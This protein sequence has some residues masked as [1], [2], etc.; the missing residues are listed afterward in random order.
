[1]GCLTN[2]HAKK[3][4]QNRRLTT[5]LTELEYVGFETDWESQLQI[6]EELTDIPNELKRYEDK[7][8]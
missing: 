3:T 6:R 2:L 7:L 5:W 4:I 8:K 1:M